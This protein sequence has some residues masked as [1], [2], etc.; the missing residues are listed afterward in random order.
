MLTSL[1]YSV[2]IPFI[3]Y[4]VPAAVIYLLFHRFYVNRM[5]PPP[6]KE[7]LTST[8]G[9]VLAAILAFIIV[10]FLWTVGIILLY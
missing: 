6:Q 8:I 3:A 5:P 7:F 9:K 10:K 2:F 4:V 1:Y